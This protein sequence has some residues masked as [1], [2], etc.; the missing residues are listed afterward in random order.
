MV[1]IVS[2]H[3]ETNVGHTKKYFHFVF[4]FVLHP[5]PPSE[6]CNKDGFDGAPKTVKIGP[7]A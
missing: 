7:T 2:G 6:I 1:N 5:P 4:L 3:T